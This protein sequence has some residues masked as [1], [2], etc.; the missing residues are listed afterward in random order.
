MKIV[1]ISGVYIGK[2]FEETD[3][4]IK[5]AEAFAIALANRGVG[6][7]CPHLNIAH[8]ETKSS[9]A[10]GFHLDLD[11]EMMSRCDGALMMPGWEKTGSDMFGYENARK[12]GML[13]FFPNSPEDTRVL[14]AIEKWAK[15]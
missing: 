12:R 6:F 11:A 2:N 9:M 1:F 13:M 4:N 3:V 10:Y 14:S 5:K 7:F 15:K 8:L